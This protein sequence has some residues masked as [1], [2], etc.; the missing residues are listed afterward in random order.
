MAFEWELEKD[1]I[2]VTS[3]Q[4]V[5]VGQEVILHWDHS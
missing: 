3:E 1:T 4:I 2:P 5:S